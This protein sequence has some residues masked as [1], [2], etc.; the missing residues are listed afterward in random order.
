MHREAQKTLLSIPLIYAIIGVVVS[1][2]LGSLQSISAIAGLT[3]NQHRIF[4]E[5][6]TYLGGGVTTALKLGYSEIHSIEID[7][8]LYFGAEFK[9][10]RFSNVH[11]HL[12]SS[13]ELLENLLESLNHFHPNVP[14]L[15]WLDAHFPGSD[16]SNVSYLEGKSTYNRQEWLPILSEISIISR[17][18][19]PIDTIVIDDLR[20][21]S[22]VHKT[23][24]SSLIQHLEQIGQ[25]LPLG[26]Q[27]AD[28]VG[29]S[30]E[31][32][33]EI[34]LPTHKSTY[35]LSQEGYIVSTP[36]SSFR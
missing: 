16:R 29:V 11:I 10:S 7:Q 23:Q 9:F 14:I 35:Y 32:I 34:L 26:V 13:P 19:P 2:L 20:C 24:S 3:P 22:D 5:T 18:R 6:G 12:G 8:E 1:S 15:F 17:I 4:V 31:Q 25:K 30:I 28:L 21:F 33:E 36:H 27:R